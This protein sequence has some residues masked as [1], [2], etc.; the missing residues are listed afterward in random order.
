MGCGQAAAAHCWL[1]SYGLPP[2]GY[3]YLSKDLPTIGSFASDCHFDDRHQA[4]QIDR[5]AGIRWSGPTAA[6]LLLS[7]LRETRRSAARDAA[8]MA[9]AVA[10]GAWVRSDTVYC[11]C[12]FAT[13]RHPHAYAGCHSP[14]QQ[15]EV[16]AGDGRVTGS[17]FKSVVRQNRPIMHEALVPGRDSLRVDVRRGPT[18]MS[19]CRQ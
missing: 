14:E 17:G 5:H 6:A 4:C 1:G 13:P 12:R 10:A 7:A 16:L 8:A 9:A 2:P 11:R 19:R 15:A 3:A 18:L